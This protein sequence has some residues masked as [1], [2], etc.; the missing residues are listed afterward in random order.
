MVRITHN[1]ILSQ[2][3]TR[4]IPS[5]SDGETFLFQEYHDSVYSELV[6]PHKIIAIPRYFLD[7]WLPVLG[8]SPAWLVVA[9]RQAAFVY[10]A[11]KQQVVRPLAV[12]CLTRWSGLSHGQIWNILQK[13]AFLGWFVRKESQAQSKRESNIWEIQTS[14]P[15]TPQ[16]IICLEEFALGQRQARSDV[17]L[18]ELLALLRA[19]ATDIIKGSSRNISDLQVNQ[20]SLREILEALF[21]PFDS[22]DLLV[23]EEILGR[24]TQP[25]NTIA[26]TH[27]FID[28]WRPQLTSGEAWLIHVLRS[29]VYSTSQNTSRTK[30]KGGKVGLAEM[31]GVNVRSMRRWFSD[32]AGSNLNLFLSVNQMDDTSHLS[33]NINMRDPVCPD[34]LARYEEL[35]QKSKETPADA[36]GQNWITS[37]VQINGQQDKNGHGKSVYPEKGLTEIDRTQ[38]KI[39]H[40]SGQKLTTL[41]TG[42][43]TLMDLNSDN[44]KISNTQLQPTEHAGAPAMYMGGWSIL[45]LFDHS[46]LPK[47]KKAN[48]FAIMGRQP[49]KTHSFLGW[50]IYGYE[51]RGQTGSGISAPILFA[52]SRYDQ[53]QPADKYISLAQESPQ[54]LLRLMQNRFSPGVSPLWR[55]ILD[56]LEANGFAEILQAQGCNPDASQNGKEKSPEIPYEPDMVSNLA[57]H[58]SPELPAGPLSAEACWH[59]IRELAQI[60]EQFA[61]FAIWLNHNRLELTFLHSESTQAVH[62]LITRNLHL[63]GAQF[64]WCSLRLCTLQV[65]SPGTHGTPPV[66]TLSEVIIDFSKMQPQHT[67]PSLIQAERV[68]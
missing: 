51:N 47:A 14:I 9:F 22:E 46:S 59:G 66:E 65:A 15:L 39:E 4:Q 7:H 3:P 1:H 25:G 62:G 19:E 31:L 35:I 55:P 17:S 12:R 64:S 5:S 2:G 24:I 20:V 16:H 52:L 67:S 40:R 13:N 48:L 28:H 23:Y 41:V 44:N 29:H 11:T 30:V 61:P 8:P 33:L 18:K 32:L 6:A 68:H 42:V 37:G 45:N 58:I 49:E 60:P 26:I 10:H 54:N 21:G 53:N 50:L 63:L 36:A 56:A 38:D 57:E 27:Y 43:D 34:D